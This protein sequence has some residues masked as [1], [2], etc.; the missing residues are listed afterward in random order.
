MCGHSRGE[1]RSRIVAVVEVI[2]AEMGWCGCKCVTVV[3][4]GT[5]AGS[6]FGSV[7]YRKWVAMVVG[8][9]ATGMWLLW[10]GWQQVCLF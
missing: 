9:M 4:G 5:V 3:V 1:Y 6:G 10:I 7:W 2:T 8:V